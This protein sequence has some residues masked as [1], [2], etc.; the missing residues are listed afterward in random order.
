[1]VSSCSLISLTNDSLVIQVKSIIKEPTAGSWA[2][3][4]ATS[5]TDNDDD[6]TM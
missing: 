3:T 2:A 1:M 4:A 6:F 5:I